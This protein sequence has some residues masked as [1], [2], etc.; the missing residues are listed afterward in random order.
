M[1]TEPARELQEALDADVVYSK[2]QARWNERVIL[3]LW[4]ISLAASVAAAVVIAG[5]W[6]HRAVQSIIA[7]VPAAVQSAL[8]VFKFQDKVDWHLSKADELERLAHQLRY[9]GGQVD[10][11]SEK[12]NDVNSEM[13]RKRPR[14]GGRVRI[15]T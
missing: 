9:R 10:L 5:G 3:S 14:T 13:N 2:R 6:G 15:Q 1:A 11:I 12:R 7:L 8:A 4:F